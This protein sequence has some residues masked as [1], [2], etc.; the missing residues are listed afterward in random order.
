MDVFELHSDLIADYAAY[1]R[2]FIRISDRR[3]SEAV[4][5]EISEGLLW[6]EPLLQLNPSFEPGATI[7]ELVADGTLHEE[8]RRIFRIKRHEDDFGVPLRLHRHQ[9]QAIR[10]AALGHS[11]VLTT[12]TGSGK[13]L[14]YIIPAVDYVLRNGGKRGIQAIVVYPMNALAN[15]QREELDKFLLRGY[16]RG[17]SPV[18]YARYT[19]QEGD[20]VRERILR[21]PPD[22]LLTNYVMLELILTRIDERALVNAAHNLRYLVFDELHTYRGRQGADVSMLIRRCR[23]AFQSQQLRCVGTSATMA[24]AGTG[25]NQ[26]RVV[27][28]VATTIFGEPIAA[29]NVIGE[30]LRRT[31]DDVNFDSETVKS[32]I[33]DIIE[34]GDVGS[35]DFETFRQN[36]LVAWIE[37]TFGLHTEQ[38]TGRL[39]RRTPRPLRGEL[40]ASAELAQ[41]AGVDQD[42]AELAI[43]RFLYAG[44]AVT[45]PVTGF[46]LFAF[47]LHQ[48]ISRG[49]TVWASLEE[50]ESRYITLRGQQYVPGHR[51]KV[52]LFG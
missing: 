29:E 43:Q 36:P 3:I 37:T 50:E 15:S 1:T 6:P 25:E 27:S 39:I 2:S 52:L 12:G 46:P 38:E 42:L 8:C 49:D 9:E 20:E 7:D 5:R 18:T 21:E 16:E 17:Q 44:S 45:H 51:D 22:I 31:T 10:T 35:T 19:G 47:R 11:Y 48:F 4:D 14:A 32:A 34:S 13:S 24:S 23:E 30:T 33:R 26:A 28:E 40:G 41:L